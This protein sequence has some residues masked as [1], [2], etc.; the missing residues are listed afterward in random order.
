MPKNKPNAQTIATAKY[1]E[2]AGYKTVS[3]KMRGDLPVQFAEACKRAG[4]SKASV[5]SE[6][7]QEFIETNREQKN[8]QG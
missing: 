3:F 1:Q 5:I 7:M 6:L 4:R 8:G 2:K